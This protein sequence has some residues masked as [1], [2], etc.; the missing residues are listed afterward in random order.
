MLISSSFLQWLATHASKLFFFFQLLSCWTHTRSK[1]AFFPP[2]P[3]KLNIT[4]LMQT[5]EKQPKQLT[6]RLSSC[7]VA[8][9]AVPKIARDTAA[10]N[11]DSLSDGHCLR[12]FWKMLWAWPLVILTVRPR[13]SKTGLQLDVVTSHHFSSISLMDL[14]V[15]PWLFKQQAWLLTT[16]LLH[17]LLKGKWMTRTCY[18]NW[19]PLGKIICQLSF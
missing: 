1:T 15:I 12:L 17:H 6:H 10:T 2:R 19:D 14:F 16:Y 8:L 9:W 7:L 11:Q 3:C 13:N 4:S 5:S 18:Q